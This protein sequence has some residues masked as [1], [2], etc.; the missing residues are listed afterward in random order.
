[1]PDRNPLTSFTTGTHKE[2]MKSVG[3]SV[4]NLLFAG[5]MAAMFG[6]Y[7]LNN[8]DSVEYQTRGADGRGDRVV[9]DC[10]SSH[11]AGEINNREE[12]VG[13][14][15]ATNYSIVFD[16]E[17][18][19]GEVNGNLYNANVSHHMRVWFEWG[20]IIQ[21]TGFFGAILGLVGTNF[22]STN[23]D[24]TAEDVLLIEKHGNVVKLGIFFM[25]MA[26]LVGGFAWMIIGAV[27]RFRF[28]GRVCSGDGNYNENLTPN[29][30]YPKGMMVQSG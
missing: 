26:Q 12:E 13:D 6:L 9:Y 10:W 3:L 4:F 16:G 20:F 19:N 1:M 30:S 24:Q 22:K 5:V 2:P 28:T 29:D 14:S 11:Q 15:K 21:L 7:W 27:I 17:T 8:P 25:G 23:I 18:P